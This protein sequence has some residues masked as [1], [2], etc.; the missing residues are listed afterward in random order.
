MPD[1][2]WQLEQV[3]LPGAAGRPRLANLSLTIERGVTAILGPSGAGKTSI[4]NLLVGFESAQRGEVRCSF[5]RSSARAP[6]LFWS[7]ADFGLWPH[8]SVRDHLR[9]VSPS[10]NGQ[11]GRAAEELLAAFDL[12]D[13]ADARPATLSLG[14]RSRLA[15]ARCL[16]SE[17]SVLVMDEPLA[18]VDSAR[19]VRFWAVIR[20]HAA[21]RGVSLVFCTHQPHVVLAEARHVVCL[22][23]GQLVFAGD[24]ETLYSA[25]PT[26]EAARCLGEVNWLPREAAQTWGITPRQ[27]GS[28]VCIRPE[29]L[30]IVLAPDSAIVVEASHFRGAESDSALRHDSAGI[31]QRFVHRSPVPPLQR[32]ERVSLR[33]LLA[34]LMLVAS[35]LAGCSQG[36]DP[37]LAVKSFQ[38]FA[39]PPDETTSPPPRAVAV[40]VWPV[41]ADEKRG[42]GEMIVLDKAGRVLVY[43]EAFQLRRQ[44]W[45]P[46]Y[47]AG[48]PEGACLLKNG[49]IAVADTHYNRIVIFTQAGEVVRMFGSLG[50]E[51]GQFIYPVKVV[52]DAAG[53]LYVLEYGGN[54][55]VQKFTAQ[56]E[57]LAT[58]GSSGTGIG[59][60]Q[61]AAGLV[62]RQGKIYIADAD[63]HRV[64]VFSDDGK[65]LGAL[66][67]VGKPLAL[68][69]PYDLATGPDDLLYIIEYGGN[70]LTV[71]TFEGKLIGRYGGPGRGE[72]Q[73]L[74]PWGVRVD[75][76]GRVWIADTGNRRMVVLEK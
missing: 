31:S 67:E 56:G 22:N 71:A 44:W 65:H 40:N 73:F 62:W 52:E 24:V 66:G 12:S 26:L 53:S 15:V 68:D 30:Q 27:A 25:P 35:Q 38:Y 50:R 8:L 57:F 74:T 60:L 11:A 1:P 41:G 16:A 70:R 13:R 34:L 49:H 54:D 4:L 48:K 32:G 3:E 55:R 28:H 36:D 29:H 33:W 51:P 43:D 9:A 19:A 42:A 69:F 45:M 7:P 10:R 47:S 58:F 61:R 2:L 5:A 18:H 46:Q 63:N 37:L 20:E 76:R 14:E 21:T 59:Q 75:P 64:Q 17:A 6:S 39:M 72:G 23:E